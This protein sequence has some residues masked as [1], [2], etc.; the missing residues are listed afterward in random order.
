GI[1]WARQVGRM[2]AVC[3]PYVGA[4]TLW[5]A[6]AGAFR[7]TPSS[8]SGRA[9][10]A[11][12]PNPDLPAAPGPAT[13]LTGR[14]AYPPPVAPG[15]ARGAD[16]VAYI[17]QAGLVHGDL[18]P[19]NILLAPGGHPYLIDFN[20]AGAGADPLRCGGTLPYMAPERLWLMLGDGAAGNTEAKG[21][22][23]AADVYA[24][25][26]VLFETLTGRVPFQP[27]ESAGTLA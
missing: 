19:S 25:G 20:L 5:D 12:P 17:P 21:P 7:D 1:L 23:T 13:L 3:L 8:P 15:A 18:K 27:P 22:A 16:A 4:V 14:Q 26:V 6:V 11:P 24:F 2:Y 9:L 10:L